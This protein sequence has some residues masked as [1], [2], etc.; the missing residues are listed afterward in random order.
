MLRLR[1]TR[2]CQPR[3]KNGQPPHSTTGV[4]KSSSSQT[5]A[6]GEPSHAKDTSGIIFPVATITS[7]TVNRVLIQKR[8]VRSTGC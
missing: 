8:R 5:R 3:S 2:D 4:A 7:G 6:R 1:L